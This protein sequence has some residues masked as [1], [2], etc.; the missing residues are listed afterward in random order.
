MS[1]INQ[2]E[3][4]TID[5][6]VDILNGTAQP[7]ETDTAGESDKTA[8]ANAEQVAAK[9]PDEAGGTA[10]T[11]EAQEQPDGEAEQGEQSAE[12]KPDEAPAVDYSMKVKFKANGV[13]HEPSIQELIELAQKGLN[14]DGKMQEM[15]EQRK[16]Y[17][18]MQQQQAQQQQQNPELTYEDINREATARAMKELGIT[19]PENFIPDPMGIVGNRAHYAA[20]Q[21]AL[22]QIGEEQR[23]A[24]QQKA[25]AQVVAQQCEDR[26]TAFAQET[27]QDT[28][29]TEYAIERLK[30]VEPLIRGGHLHNAITKV[31]QRERGQMVP[32]IPD[33]LAALTDFY[34][35]CRA[36]YAGKQQKEQ[37][38]AQ[39]PKSAPIKPTVQVEKTA[40][41]EPAPAK[42]LDMKKIRE[43]DIDQIAKL[44]KD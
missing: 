10:E 24:N 32:F 36:D 15:A 9:Q 23:T 29:L 42:K 37:V 30:E 22:W 1:D 2:G 13:E 26:F 43:M 35:K 39:V 31:V 5:Q 7:A 4:Y 20:Y 19:D 21:K 18:Q 33:E 12:Q 8:D 41:G 3:G 25:Q 40:S 14:Y 28:K 38:K 11:G 6:A 34:E 17:E 16:A 44:L 27:Q